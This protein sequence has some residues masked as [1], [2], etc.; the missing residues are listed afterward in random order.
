MTI[1]PGLVTAIDF[2]EHDPIHHGITFRT[3]AMSG[4]RS[5]P[6]DSKDNR[7]RTNKSPSAG[8]QPPRAFRDLQVLSQGVLDYVDAQKFTQMTPVQA[9]TIPLFLDHKDVAVQAVTGSGKTLAFLIPIMELLRKKTF[10]K[11]Q[12]GALVLSPTRELAVQTHAVAKGLCEACGRPE[13][14]LLTGGSSS[15]SSAASSRPV[16]ADLRTFQQ[17]GSDIIIGTPGRVED[18]L[19]KYAIIDTSELEVLVLDVSRIL[20]VLLVDSVAFVFRTVLI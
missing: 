15:K 17:T 3:R 12:I 7:E 18:V 1:V 5:K 11:Q 13:P 16:T 9:A 20:V 19:T 10:K 6:C 4:K 14:L 2:T 8:R